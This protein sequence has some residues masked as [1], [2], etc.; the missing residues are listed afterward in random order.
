LL[1]EAQSLGARLLMRQ[2]SQGEGVPRH[3]SL[4]LAAAYRDLFHGVLGDV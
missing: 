1:E 2:V 4:R 3:D